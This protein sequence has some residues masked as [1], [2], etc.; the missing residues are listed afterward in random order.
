MFLEKGEEIKSACH[1]D[2]NWKVLLNR[3]KHKNVIPVIGQGLY[4][5]DIELEGKKNYLLYDYL[6]ERIAAE[7]GANIHTDENH[8]FAKACFEFLKKKKGDDAYL[9]LS[10]FLEKLLGGVR[11]IPGSSLW[12]LA[13][14][15]KLGI[16]INTAYD[17]L[18]ESAI[19]KVRRAKTEIRSYTVEEKYL[20]FLDKQLFDA[21]DKFKC[22]L[23]YQI[24]GNFGNSKPAFAEKDILETIVEFSKDMKENTEKNFFQK[25]GS[26][27]L[28]F[29]GCGYDDWLFRFFIRILSNQPYEFFGKNSDFKIFA[30]D[31]FCNSKKDPFFDLLRF[32]REHKVVDCYPGKGEDFVHLLFEKL[33]KDNDNGDEIIQPTDF[34]EIFISFEGKDRKAAQRL[35]DN[36]KEDGMGVWL[37]EH[38]FKGGDNVDDKIIKAINKY[39]VFMPLV[40]RNSQ[41]LLTD[42]GKLKYHIREWEQAFTKSVEEKMKIIPVIIDDTNWV[43]DKFSGIFHYNI[44][45]GDRLEDYEKLKDQLIKLLR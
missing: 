4:R 5:V 23:V 41:Q 30:S 28:L 32:L 42:E 33:N 22:T 9:D 35:T 39:P 3:I 44:P 6:A 7:C 34:P 17:N 27:S 31:D 18:L 12:K 20:D 40:S 14:I 21:I 16:F 43:Y 36:L 29:I 19:N 37:D 13:R 8:K 38:E 24:F 1:K 26:K 15:K 10:D 25:L 45:S 2:F 11:L